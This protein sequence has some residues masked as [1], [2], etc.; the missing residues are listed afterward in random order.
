MT[1]E[2][3]KDEPNCRRLTIVVA[4]GGPYRSGLL[5]EATITEPLDRRPSWTGAPTANPAPGRSGASTAR[6]TSDC[7]APRSTPS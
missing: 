1:L 2:M 7:V 5:C 4:I 6:V 3:T